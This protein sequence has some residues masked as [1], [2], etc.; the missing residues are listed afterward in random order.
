MKL[1][2]QGIEL[3]DGSVGLNEINSFDVW[4][5]ENNEFLAIDNNNAKRTMRYKVI[6][7]FNV[8]E[9]KQEILEY[10]LGKVTN[11]DEL[12]MSDIFLH[13]GFIE[14]II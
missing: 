1:I 6:D 11:N 2:L 8:S 9:H 4:T 14:K 10:C 3:N 7:T 12:T 5:Y 13:G